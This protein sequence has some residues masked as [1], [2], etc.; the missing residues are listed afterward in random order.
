M[1]IGELTDL[2]V[3]SKAKHVVLTGG[4]PML[5]PNIE[6]L[7]HALHAAGMHITIETAGTISRQVPCDLMSLSPKLSNSTPS[8][9]DPRD[10]KG[11][12]RVMHESRRIN[13]AALQSLIDSY[14]T[15]QLKFVVKNDADIAEIKDLLSHL[16]GWIADDILL[17]PEGVTLP[18]QT[19]K[20]WLVSQ[21]L[22]NSWRYCPRLHIDLFGNTRGT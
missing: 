16:T 21:C 15:R 10:P 19:F 8:P 1:S 2:A 9:T 22:E 4:E 6:P 18:S 20:S 5:F 7:A 13:L 17:M 14:P 3:G 11:A 12:L